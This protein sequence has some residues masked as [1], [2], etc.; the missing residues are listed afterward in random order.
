MSDALLGARLARKYGF[1]GSHMSAAVVTELSAVR[2]MPWGRAA[3]LKF[4]TD[5]ESEHSALS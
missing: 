1:G 2:S 5:W 3:L 4:L